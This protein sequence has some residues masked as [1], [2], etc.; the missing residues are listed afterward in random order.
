VQ[1]TS[2]WSGFAQ[3]TR[4]E[5]AHSTTQLEKLRQLMTLPDPART[6]QRS[7]SVHVYWHRSPQIT[8]QETVL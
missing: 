3:L 2:H 8:P 1:R 7:T 6:P 4:H 5:P